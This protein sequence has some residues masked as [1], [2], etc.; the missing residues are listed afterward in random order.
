MLLDRR[1]DPGL[2]VLPVACKPATSFKRRCLD[3]HISVLGVPY[4]TMIPCLIAEL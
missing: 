2:P 1:S 4:K 3:E